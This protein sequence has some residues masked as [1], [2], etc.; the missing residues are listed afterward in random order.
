M[1]ERS[2]GLDLVRTLAVLCVLVTHAIA[3]TGV[4]DVSPAS[5]V[6]CVYLVLRF[7]AMAGVPL[8]L[9]LSGYLCCEKRLSHT[10]YGGGISVVL[11]YV[12]IAAA[13]VILCTVSGVQKYT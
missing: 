9:L 5:P 6:W 3:Y 7:A 13:V 4:M 8:F 1:K 12:L 10:Y 2:P 11:S